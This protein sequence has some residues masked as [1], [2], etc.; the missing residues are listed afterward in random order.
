MNDDVYSLLFD[1]EDRLWIGSYRG[2]LALVRGSQAQIFNSSNGSVP[3]AI[4]SLYEDVSGALWVGSSLGMGR[5]RN[6]IWTVW[7]VKQGLPSADVQD[8]IE[9]NL[10]GV[11]LTTSSGLLH[12]DAGELSRQPDGFSRPF[13]FDVYGFADGVRVRTNVVRSQPRIAKSP[14]GTLWFASDAGAATVDPSRLQKNRL[15]PPVLIEGFKV[16]GQEVDLN[17]SRPESLEFRARELQF[18]FTALSLT[19]PET[20]R[21]RYRL[22]GYDREWVEAGTRR[23]AFYTNIPP[24]RYR[25]GVIACNND[26][27]W[28][29]KQTSLSLTLLP[30]FYLRLWFQVPCFAAAIAIFW[31]IYRLRLA[32]IAWQ[33]ERHLQARLGERNRI[34]RELHDTLLQNVVG[35]SLQLEV[36]SKRLPENDA[37]KPHLERVRRHVDLS[38]REA[39]QSVMA[40]RS[41]TMENRD[42]I[43]AL[44][45]IGASLTAGHAI[46]FQASADGTPHACPPELQEQLLRIGREAIGNAVTHSHCSELQV[47]VSYQARSICLRIADNGTGI[48]SQV[49]ESG[50]PGHFGLRGMKERAESIGGTFTVISQPS[51]G[52]VITVAAPLHERFQKAG[53][54]VERIR[55]ASA[56]LLGDHFIRFSES[57]ESGQPGLD[58]PQQE[59]GSVTD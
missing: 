50:R 16:D 28:D 32:Q 9:D 4:L 53:R 1:R 5:F 39:R 46:R 18:D 55:A 57:A 22:E 2:G 31:G 10:G 7:S 29:A 17:S 34:A 51:G 56:R 19:A 30:P 33:F 52:T 42:L 44:G 49:L 12:A 21:F 24:G 45:E 6:G 25:F 14:N 41:P 36:I 37:E 20:I 15:P 47:Q 40:L 43:T 8:I 13:R 59:A 11:W 38:L 35:I 54:L 48:E 58:A 26:G 27:V 23:Q 3:G